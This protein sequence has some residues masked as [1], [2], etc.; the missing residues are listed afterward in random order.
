MSFFVGQQGDR[1]NRPVNATEF[2]WNRIK[3]AYL[4][5]YKTEYEKLLRELST[6]KPSTA[7]VSAIVD[8]GMAAFSLTDWKE[9]SFVPNTTR[10]MCDPATYPDTIKTW[11]RERNLEVGRQIPGK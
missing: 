9:I 7:T 4:R 6:T 10:P 1:S 11:T 5:A 2:Y 8:E 3:D